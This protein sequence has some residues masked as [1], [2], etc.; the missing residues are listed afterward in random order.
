MSLL[1]GHHLP[2]F[3]LATGGKTL[4]ML[5]PCQLFLQGQAVEQKDD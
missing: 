3:D 1:A 2:L 5:V 4:A